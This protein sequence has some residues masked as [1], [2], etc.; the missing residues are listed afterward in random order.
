[1]NQQRIMIQPKTNFGSFVFGQVKDL[2]PY[3]TFLKGWKTNKQSSTL[4]L[5]LLRK[6]IENKKDYL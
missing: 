1:M 6:R 4:W 3:S 5:M 2:G